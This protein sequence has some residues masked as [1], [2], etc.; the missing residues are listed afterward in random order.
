M[1]PA[2]QTMKSYN[3]AGIFTSRDYW[4]WRTN[5]HPLLFLY[6]PP[7]SLHPST[8]S[9]HRSNLLDACMAC[10]V[11]IWAGG[12]IEGIDG[13]SSYWLWIWVSGIAQR[14]ATM[15]SI[16]RN[17]PFS[18]LAGGVSVRNLAGRAFLS[19]YQMHLQEGKK[20]W[21]GC[22][23]LSVTTRSSIRYHLSAIYLWK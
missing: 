13:V 8:H 1:C 7:P 22:K 17:D 3:V 18:H 23:I 14:H 6:Y 19:G 4:V 11:A 21:A 9:Q 5:G 2:G 16:K 20:V 15:A 10:Q 12:G